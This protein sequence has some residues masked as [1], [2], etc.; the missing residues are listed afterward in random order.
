[1]Q[2]LVFDSFLICSSSRL[3]KIYVSETLI[4]S[5]GACFDIVSHD[6]CSKIVYLYMSSSFRKSCLL[7][8]F[9]S[10]I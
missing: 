5:G 7:L 6:L 4:C 10:L 2:G 9:P 3:D 1:M 8:L